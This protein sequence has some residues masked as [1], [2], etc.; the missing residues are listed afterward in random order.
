VHFLE[1]FGGDFFGFNILAF[2]ISTK[3]QFLDDSSTSTAG[4]EVIY[5][6]HRAKVVKK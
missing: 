1:L 2:E 5:L 6:I 3:F 4:G